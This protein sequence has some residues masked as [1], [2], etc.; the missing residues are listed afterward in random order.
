MYAPLDA[1]NH[2]VPRKAV[3]AGDVVDDDVAGR[4][5]VAADVKRL[6]C[7]CAEDLE[8]II[9]PATKCWT[10]YAAA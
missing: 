8:G 9:T 1:A 10:V 7:T 4:V 5:E 2:V 3:P 6:A